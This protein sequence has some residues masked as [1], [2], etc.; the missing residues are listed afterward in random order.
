MV[1][2]T[3]GWWVPSLILL[4][5]GLGGGLLLSG[6]F[7]D[8]STTTVSASTD[9]R[10]RLKA[11]AFQEMRKQA[12]RTCASVPRGVLTASFLGRSS[13]PPAG[14]DPGRYDDNYLALLYVEDIDINPI[15]LQTAAY[16]GCLIGLHHQTKAA[17]SRSVDAP[18]DVLAD[19][20]AKTT[21]PGELVGAASPETCTLAF[22]DV[23]MTHCGDRGPGGFNLMASGITCAE[24]RQLR[25][26]LGGGGAPS[27][28]RAFEGVYRPWLATGGFVNPKPTEP[29]GWT[30]W[31]RWDPEAP[32]GGVRHVC[33]NGAATVL[34][35]IG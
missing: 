17:E 9:G 34:F 2:S 6:C 26:P 28:R 32:Q 25:L 1:L 14:A 33:W 29:I 15:R 24:T 22:E 13:A 18:P 7:G 31:H 21:C 35:K 23:V 16:N 11:F 27:Y 4:A 5:S 10:A 12:K 3:R 20:G 8:T 19:G 30:C